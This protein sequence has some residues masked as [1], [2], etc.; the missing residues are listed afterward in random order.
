MVYYVVEV[1]KAEPWAQSRVGDSVGAFETLDEAL[2]YMSLSD[3]FRS[4]IGCELAVR[5]QPWPEPPV[6][7]TAA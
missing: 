7:R 2:Y 1:A 6:R 3:R 4:L 5:T